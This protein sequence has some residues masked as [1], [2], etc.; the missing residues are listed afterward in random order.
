MIKAIAVA[1]L[2][3]NEDNTV[4]DERDG[5]DYLVVEVLV[6][7]IVKSEPHD[8][9]GDASDNDHAPEM[10]G[11]TLLVFGLRRREWVELVPVHD[12]DGQDGADLDHHEEQGEELVRHIEMHEL[13]D[14][15]HVASRGDGKPFRDALDDAY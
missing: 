13:V 11:G 3:E 5:N 10:P 12:D 9:G 7:P 4:S 14:E 2:E 8:S 15:D 6:D 1:A